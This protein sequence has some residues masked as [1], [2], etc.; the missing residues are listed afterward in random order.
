MKRISTVFIVTIII[1][2]ITAMI[3][4]STPAPAPSPAPAPAPTVTV[5]TPGVAPTVTI[6]STAPAPAPA[7]TPTAR[8]RTVVDLRSS[9]FGTF[10]Y[11][12]GTAL[13]QSAIQHPWLRI[14][15]AESPGYTWTIEY[16]CT[17]VEARSH[18]ITG[19]N[20]ISTLEAI[21]G[22]GAYAGKD[23]SEAKNLVAAVS[24]GFGW[25]HFFT[26][27]P[28]IKTVYDIQ[29]K[30]LGLGKKTQS[31][32]GPVP[33]DWLQI[34]GIEP[35]SVEWLGSNEAT[36]ALIEGKVDVAVSFGYT[37]FGG[38]VIEESTPYSQALATK[39]PVYVLDWT[40]EGIKK[41]EAESMVGT[42]FIIPPNAVEYQP[43]PVW[44]AGYGS[45][46]GAHIDFPED[47][48]YEVVKTMLE[49]YKAWLPRHSLIKVMSPETMALSMS[50][51]YHPGAVRAY[52]EAGVVYPSGAIQLK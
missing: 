29:G 3:G 8:Q 19:W 32:W 46:W 38:D 33:Y 42:G 41:I 11:I 7:P 31:G 48:M 1:S 51:K 27:D 14:S 28:A 2:V 21:N 9:T 44:G 45:G 25:I 34:L 22:L 5:T 52:K 10:S 30:R 39:K 47:V 18:T 20:K 23:L 24:L 49:N 15:H 17:N 26:F 40:E 50:Y 36:A 12:V 13:E 35:S 6:T 16:L 4:C 43:N 37:S